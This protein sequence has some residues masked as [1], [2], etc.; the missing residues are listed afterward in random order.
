MMTYRSK[1]V[2][3]NEQQFERLMAILD[4]IAMALEETDI[5]R[6]RRSTKKII[7]EG[8]TRKA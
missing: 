2:D 4:R 6:Q 8:R 3:M 5:E 1:E 7:E